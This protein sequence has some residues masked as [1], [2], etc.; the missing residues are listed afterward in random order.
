MSPSPAADRQTPALRIGAGAWIVAAVGYFVAEA[1][2][3]AAVP[4]YSYATNYISPLGEPA[5]SPHAGLINVAF[6][7]QA[8]LFPAGAALMVVGTRARKTLPFLCFALLNGIGNG[9]VAVVHSG[10]GS[11]LHVAGAALA[12]IGGNAAILA[13]VP[14]LRRAGAP[15][16]LL[17]AS[18]T[19]GALGLLCAAAAA[20]AAPPIGVWE[21]VSVYSIFGWQTVCALY[22]VRRAHDTK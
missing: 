1:A 3:A 9:L 19:L 16:S 15:P 7:A 10:S 6:V 8:V 13:A 2:A 20:F 18:I 21:R 11:L 14:V 4:D 17:T 22:L 12:I 5:R